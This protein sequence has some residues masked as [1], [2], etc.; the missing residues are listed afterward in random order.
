MD[1]EGHGLFAFCPFRS[2]ILPGEGDVLGLGSVASADRA[3][4]AQANAERRLTLFTLRITG[5]RCG[6]FR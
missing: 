3:V 5:A 4:I 2:R 6:S 1:I